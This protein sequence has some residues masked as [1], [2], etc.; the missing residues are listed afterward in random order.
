MIRSFS[1]SQQAAAGPDRGPRANPGLMTAGSPTYA[2][3]R[4]HL[5]AAGAELSGRAGERPRTR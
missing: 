3:G 5:R 1:V 4:A 2:P